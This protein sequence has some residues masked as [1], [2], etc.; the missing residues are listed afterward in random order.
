[1]SDTEKKPPEPGAYRLTRDVKNRTPDRRKT[2]DFTAQPVWPAGLV[3]V[4]KPMAEPIPSGWLPDG[5]SAPAAPRRMEI[6]SSEGQ[7]PSL[8]PIHQHDDR[9]WDLAAAMGAIPHELE[10][11]Q[12]QFGVNDRALLHLLLDSRRVNLLQI[13]DAII[14]GEALRSAERGIRDAL[15]GDDLWSRARE[16][17]IDQIIAT[18]RVEHRGAIP[19]ELSSGTRDERCAAAYAA[20][21]ALGAT[22]RVQ[23]EARQ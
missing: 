9:F 10:T 22:I 1:M 17:K 20:G 4:V 12:I 15:Y 18:Y 7:Y 14:W 11:I 13:V 3:V 2:R 5:Q 19:G 6:L 16:E 23:R 8:Y 21:R